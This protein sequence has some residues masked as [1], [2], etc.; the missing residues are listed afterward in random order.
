MTS[1]LCEAILATILLRKDEAIKKFREILGYQPEDAD[2]H[3]NFGHTL[4]R[5]QDMNGAHSCYLNA[6]KYSDEP[7]QLIFDLADTAQIIFRPSDL[8]AA[9]DAYNE[10]L[11]IEMLLTNGDFSAAMKL[12]DLFQSTEINEEHAN[13][14][15]TSA[16]K[17]FIRHDVIV[18]CGFFRMTEGF[19]GSKLTFY[20]N[21][22]GDSDFVAKINIELADQLIDDDHGGALRDVSMVFVP[23]HPSSIQMM[24]ESREAARAKHANI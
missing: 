19:G 10:K 6:L 11:D 2:T 24:N 5:F 13:Q 1:L 15:Y 9:V 22:E 14:I 18:Q 20:A 12:A 3:Q 23:Y 8:A 17:I 21:I 7:T 4:L 16:E